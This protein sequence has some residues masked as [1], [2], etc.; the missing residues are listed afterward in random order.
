VFAVGAV[1]AWPA[2]L[3]AGVAAV[4]GHNFPVWLR[5]KG[6]KG[7]AT[8][9]GTILAAAPLVGV[10]ACAT[11]LVVAALFRYSSLA[12]LATLALAPVYAAVMHDTYGAIA[13]AFLGVLGW[14]RHHANITRL[15][16]GEEPKI[17]AKKT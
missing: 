6:G 17:G 3:I 11:W 1:W 5:F 4:V 15:R 2:G 8:T 7:M 10:L 13:F 9:L 16:R 14:V 12:A